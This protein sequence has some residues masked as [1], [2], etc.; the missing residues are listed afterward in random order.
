[1]FFP[2]TFSSSDF[3]TLPNICRIS[4][5]ISSINKETFLQSAL[6]ENAIMCITE[7]LPLSPFIFVFIYFLL[8]PIYDPP[9]LVQFLRN[10]N[11][12]RTFF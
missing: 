5:N 3:L 10:A 9:T 1:M 7:E 11:L 12:L 6:A 8:H 4:T 2:I